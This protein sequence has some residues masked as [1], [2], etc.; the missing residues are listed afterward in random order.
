MDQQPPKNRGG[1]PRIAPEDRAE[2]V[3]MRIS[4][5]ARREKLRQL[6]RAWL[7]RAIDRARPANRPQ[8][9]REA[10]DAPTPQPRS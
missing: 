8:G 2:V 1:R 5:A 7:E 4:G 3:A 6:G 10:R 9:A